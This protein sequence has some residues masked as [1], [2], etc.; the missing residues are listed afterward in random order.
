MP[1]KS[2]VVPLGVLAGVL[3]L[4][5]GVAVV[6]H[7]SPGVPA[8]VPSASASAGKGLPA[9]LVQAARTTLSHRS[10][11]LHGVPVP[12][13]DAELTGEADTA[14]GDTTQ[15]VRG[16]ATGAGFPVETRLVGDTVYLK[17]P[18]D[19]FRTDD[20]VLVAPEG[21]VWQVRPT[22]QP[23]PWSAIVL[24]GSSRTLASP[25]MLL[26]AVV[27][28]PTWQ[29]VSASRMG[30]GTRYLVNM[31]LAQSGIHLRAAVDVQGGEVNRLQVLPD[32][33]DLSACPAW[34]EK[35]QTSPLQDAISAY[36]VTGTDEPVEVTAPPVGQTEEPSREPSAEAGDA[37]PPT[38]P[39]AL[40]TGPIPLELPSD[41]TP[42][43]GLP[44]DLPR[45]TATYFGPAEP[46][47]APA[48]R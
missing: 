10:L 8:A 9:E 19:A 44:T 31:P 39:S 25:V 45:G 2:T 13:F 23:K 6:A 34:Q 29:F 21:G 24:S 14:T 3:A 1:K 33:A 22:Q 43:V 17:L 18:A 38:C 5:G 37:G 27:A 11:R 47:P 30:Q 4:S 40:P 26:R 20:D 12:G 7:G 15:R 16:A 28:D 32:T 41:L 48:G 42:P 36:L 46:S 35:L